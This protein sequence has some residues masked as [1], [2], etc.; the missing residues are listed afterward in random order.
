MA[1]KKAPAPQSLPREERPEFLAVLADLPA[2]E[3]VDALERLAAD[4]LAMF[5]DAIRGH[6]P[7]QAALAKLRY[8]A[9]VY[10]LHGDSFFGCA[11][12]DGAGMR[13]ERQLAAAPGVVP[14]WGQGGKWLVEVG[15]MRVRVEVCHGPKGTTGLKCWAVDLDAPFLS[16]TGFRSHW[17]HYDQWFGRDLG[18]AVRAELER[19]L[20]E[21]D[22][23]PVA[24]K[25]DSKRYFDASPAWLLPA[26]EGVTHNG[27]QALPLSG[28]APVELPVAP[29]EAEPKVPMSNAE[30]QRLFRQRQ[31]GRRE[32]A[33]AE[34]RRTCALSDLDL[35]RLWLALNTYIAFDPPLG[36]E[37]EGLREM[38]GRLFAHKPAAYLE[39]LGMEAEGVNNLKKQ[40]GKDAQRG[41]EAYKDERK[42]TDSLV[43][44]VNVLQQEN[45][46]L[47]STLAEIG[48][49]LGGQALAAP[50][51]DVAALQ[52]EVAR[53]RA[54]LDKQHA[55]NLNTIAELG[56]ASKVTQGMQRA[57][58]KAGLPHDY[59][60]YL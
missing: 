16:E 3:A 47:K 12:D 1:R 8:D 55:D 58:E 17:L 26:L 37:L 15:G 31:K 57:L 59:R 18:A 38:A 48:A 45:A 7:E 25:E 20:Q 6:A 32:Q 29:A 14:G 36:R 30:R 13:L 35:N 60:V 2:A 5:N 39:R 21:K 42:R 40:Q 41:W 4:S 44:R 24:I 23:Q 51:A 34:G 56:R 52:S 11:A 53:L 50:V 19:C 54:Q 43:D 27:Q 10:R 49:E 22:W 33:Q 9:V 28:R 46:A